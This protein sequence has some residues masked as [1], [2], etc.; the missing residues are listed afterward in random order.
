MIER[1]I[2]TIHTCQTTLLRK[3]AFGNCPKQYDIQLNWSEFILMG[4]GGGEESNPCVKSLNPK[5]QRRLVA[6][7]KNLVDLTPVVAFVEDA[8]SIAFSL[9]SCK[10]K[11]YIW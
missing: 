1:N 9:V 4:R 11:M 2:Q 7:G 10:K 6:S 3:S 8:D 5:I